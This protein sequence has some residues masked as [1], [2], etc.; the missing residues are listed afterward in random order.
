M[1]D[2]PDYRPVTP[3]KV[4]EWMRQ[5]VTGQAKPGFLSQLVEE[6]EKLY[7]QI[8]GEPKGQKKLW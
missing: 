4:R 6:Y 7:V 1:P 5:M 2:D 8:N 3:E